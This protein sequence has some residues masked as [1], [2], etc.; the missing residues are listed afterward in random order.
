[1]KNRLRSLPPD[2]LGGV[3]PPTRGLGA[4]CYG[5]RSCVTRA[6]AMMRVGRPASTRCSIASQPPP[7]LKLDSKAR[8]EEI[9]Q[10]IAQQ[11]AGKHDQADCQA[12][13]NHDPRRLL[14]EF[15]GGDREHPAPG[16]IWFGDPEPEETQGRLHQD[17]AGK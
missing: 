17:R 14:R 10:R 15:R 8:V 16:R 4:L 13:K 12:R 9:P 3:P 2:Y 6:S 11:V 7:P 5:D 1:M